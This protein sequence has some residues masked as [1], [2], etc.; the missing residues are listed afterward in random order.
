MVR[1]ALGAT[2]ITEVTA[3]LALRDSDGLTCL[4]PSVVVAAGYGLAFLLPVQALKSLG[5]G[6]ACAM[7][8]GLGMVG[9]AVGRWGVV[10]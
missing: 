7:W 1:I 4:W 5:V 9:A 10:R 8:S 6:T 2:I 3:T